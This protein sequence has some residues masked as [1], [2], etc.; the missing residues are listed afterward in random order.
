[1]SRGREIDDTRPG[2]QQRDNPVHQHEVAE[3]VGSKLGLETVGSVTE[4]TGHHPGVGDDEIE[5]LFLR[6]QRLSARP[7]T[8]ERRQVEFDEFQAAPVRGVGE[9]LLCRPLGL[10]QIACSTD[11]LGPMCRESASGFH[12]QPGR[13]AGDQDTLAAQIDARKDLV[14]G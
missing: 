5:A 6:K 14:S 8:G 2:R 7:D 1:V 3:V 4:G 12:A 10:R 11:H 9:N 13:N